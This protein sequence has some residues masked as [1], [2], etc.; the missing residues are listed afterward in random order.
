MQKNYRYFSLLALLL[1]SF[2]HFEPTALGVDNEVYLLVLK[3]YT[4]KGKEEVAL[5]NEIL[6]EL[7]DKGVK[8]PKTYDLFEIQNRPALLSQFC[9]GYHPLTATDAEIAAIAKEMALLHQMDPPAQLP[10]PPFPDQELLSDF[11]ERCPSLPHR[12]FVQS[13][14][15]QLDFSYLPL[16]PKGLVH[17]DFSPSNLLMQEEEVIAL[18]D[19]DHMGYT[20]L[21]SDL[22]RAQISFSFVGENFSL[23]KCADFVAS[24]EKF[25]PLTPAEKEHFFTHLTAHLLRVYLVT[26]YYVEERKEVDPSIFTGPRQYQSH[27]ALYNKLLCLSSMSLLPAS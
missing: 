11:L 15:A 7:R 14:I 5:L 17:G 20:Y 24:Y 19:F 27:Q 10:R 21:L 23:K 18:L 26:Y 25:R 22:A 6:E 1:C 9:Y 3:V 16:L 8:I 13:L 12:E 4:K 2:I